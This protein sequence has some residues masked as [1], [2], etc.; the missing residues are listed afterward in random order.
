MK[1]PAE[2]QADEVRPELAVE[3]SPAMTQSGHSAGSPSARTAAF[4]GGRITG[5]FTRM[6]AAQWSSE[7]ANGRR[8][9]RWVALVVLLAGLGGGCETVEDV[10]LTY[11]LWDK[12]TIS[13]CQPAPNPKLAVFN[14]P[15]QHDF[16]VEYDAIS[17]QHVK[18]S[19]LAYFMDTS[20]ARIEQGK[21]PHFIK[22][23][24]FPNLQPIPY[25]VST[26]EYVLVSTNGTSFT[27]FQPNQPP[28][29]HD[30]PFYQDDHWSA[31]RVALTPFAVTGDAVL[32][33]ACAGVMAV[34]M[35]CENGTAIR[36]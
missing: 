35:L 14:V 1:L 22:P 4:G 13:F 7:E 8:G 15:A 12:D 26:N 6:L 33:G 9:W 23:G 27:L 10:S 19:R 16:L 30:L 21:A 20:E 28:E 25:E 5:R 31:T 36:P 11:K 18:V 32:V 34:W 24:Q 3:S 17:D 2:K 29:H